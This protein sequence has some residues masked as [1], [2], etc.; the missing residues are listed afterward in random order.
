MSLQRAYSG[1]AENTM[2]DSVFLSRTIV[3]SVMR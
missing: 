2:V 3:C 1:G